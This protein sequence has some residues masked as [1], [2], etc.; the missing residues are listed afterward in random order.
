MN[1]FGHFQDQ[2]GNAA[3][4]M[5]F[6]PVTPSW[7]SCEGFDPCSVSGIQG[8]QW[9]NLHGETAQPPTR[10]IS[11]EEVSRGGGFC[12]D[13]LAFRNPDFFYGRTVTFMC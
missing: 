6:C 8:E 12:L 5:R 4:K 13:S 2:S 10:V 1:F 3:K 7:E 9:V 11:A